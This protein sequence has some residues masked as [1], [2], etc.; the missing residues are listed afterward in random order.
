LTARLYI[1]FLALSLLFSTALPKDLQAQAPAFGERVRQQVVV[2]SVLISGYTRTQLSLIASLLEFEAGDTLYLDRLLLSLESSRFH[3]FRSRLFS[4]VG[5]TLLYYRAGHT[6]VKVSVREKPLI[7]ASVSLQLADRNVSE[8]WKLHQFS[9]RR[10]TAGAGIF[11][12]NPFGGGEQFS[13]YFET[14]FNQAGSVQLIMPHLSSDYKWG[15]EVKAALARKRIFGM[16]YIDNRLGYNE[17]EDF[18]LHEKAYSLALSY[19]PAAE[20][21]IRTSLSLRSARAGEEVLAENPLFFGRHRE[22]RYLKG[23]AEFQ[24]NQSDHFRYPLN[25]TELSISLSQSGL[26]LLSDVNLTELRVKAGLYQKWL[27][28]WY[29]RHEIKIRISKGEE[30]NFFLQRA[31]GFGQEL[32]RGYE[33]SV[34]SGQHYF[35]S[36]NEIK[37]HAVG[38]DFLPPKS[39]SRF[40]RN[41]PLDIYLKILVDGGV[42]LNSDGDSSDPLAN[43]ALFG[44]GIGIDLVLLNEYAFSVAYTVNNMLQKGIYLHLNW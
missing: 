4:D 14:G 39:V 29:S 32:V 13:A 2:D 12:N 30:D 26:A 40:F 15:V 22:L 3:L 24:M 43:K 10:I 25:G 7:S 9:L 16:Q 18:A 41:L 6:A 36:N 35:I 19:R 31:F 17:S 21:L 33:L 23:V 5:V 34:I 37:W 38:I 28:D 44:S 27:P 42:V 20:Y 11:A 1:P 8:W